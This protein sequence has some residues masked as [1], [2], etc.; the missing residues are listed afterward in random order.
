MIKMTIEK[1]IEAVEMYENGYRYDEIA[2]KMG[3]SKSSIYNF[4]RYG[5]K[6]D[7]PYK[8]KLEVKSM[9]DREKIKQ[10]ISADDIRQLKKKT[11]IGKPVRFLEKIHVGDYENTRE[12]R[13]EKK[14]TVCGMYN[15][16]FVVSF[17]G[18]K[19]MYK[20]AINWVDVLSVQDPDR[21][22]VME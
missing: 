9:T 21:I 20:E 12:T 2:K 18:K 19:G 15:D 6:E 5:S 22:I 16:Y 13:K 14:A 3:V 1:K 11:Y 7:I 10:A 4:F 17:A 8:K